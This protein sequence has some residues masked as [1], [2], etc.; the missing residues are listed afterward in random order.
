MLAEAIAAA[1]W[2]EGWDYHGMGQFGMS[3][4][5]LDVLI[6]A[7]ARTGGDGG[8]VLDKLA[9]LAP[10]SEFSHFRAV[11]LYLIAHPCPEAAEP[12]ERLLRTEGFSGHAIRNL[13]DVLRGVRGSVI[14]TTVRN[15]Q[16]KELYAA[17]ALQSCDPASPLAGEILEQYR[18]SMQ[19]CYAL[20]AWHAPPKGRSFKE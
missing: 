14:D 8:V 5:P 19:A 6:M 17:K 3:A 15:A 7:Y 18:N 20:F 10:V 13:R 2:D 1:E 16:L 9:R 11:S 12:L 4:S